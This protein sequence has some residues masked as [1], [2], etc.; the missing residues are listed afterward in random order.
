MALIPDNEQHAEQIKAGTKGR[1]RGHKFE[2]I[3]TDELNRFD[4]SSLEIPADPLPHLV[5]GFPAVELVKYIAQ[6]SQLSKI[7]RVRAWWVG[8]LATSGQ[9]DLL[10]DE[11]GNPVTK[12]KSDVV[13]EIEHSEGIRKT[14]VSVKTCSKKTPTNAQL[15]FTTAFRFCE[16]LRENGIPVTQDAENALRMFCGDHG[17]RPL[18]TPEKLVNRKSDPERYFWEELP[19]KGRKDLEEV[20]SHYQNEITRLLLQKAYNA[21]PYPPEFILHQTVAYTDIHK[22]PMALFTVEELIQLSRNYH[23]FHKKPYYVKKGR[24]KGDPHEHQAPR[25]G[26]VQF[27]RGG[28]KQHPT[29]LQFNLQAGYFNKI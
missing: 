13:I 18:D 22:C 25:F 27:Q 5:T 20:F 16:F 7:Y 10:T 17:Y 4:W 19:E 8:G 26:F 14:G 21:D 6:R 9:G 23:G 28:Q 3:L 12:C 11:Y 24:F 29:Q 1:N 15:Y 2:K